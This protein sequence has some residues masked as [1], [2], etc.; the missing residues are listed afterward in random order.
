M[1]DLGRLRAP[2]PHRTDAGRN[3]DAILSTARTAF[4][5]LGTDAPLEEI[6]R[7]AGVGIATLYRNFPTRD[8]LIE[9]VYITEVEAVRQAADD[10][11]GLAPADAL[12]AWLRRFVEYIGTKR[13]L[14]AGM[15]RDSATFKSCREALYE[16]GEPLLAR[17]QRDGSVRPD[18]TI[19]DVIRL[20]SGVAG[21][22]FVNADQREHLL[23][24]AFDGL[25][26]ARREQH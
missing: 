9:N 24:V 23:A 12:T 17:A 6:A 20:V 15:N 13:A 2:R 18:V 16:A 3:Y 21:V 22:D 19:D 7:R 5:E 4:A 8:L 26:S 14:L 25:R 1:T 10:L 11:A